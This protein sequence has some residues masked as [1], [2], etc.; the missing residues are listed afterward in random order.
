MKIRIALC[1][2]F[3]VFK[4][5]AQ[6]KILITENDEVS[7][8]ETY[9]SLNSEGNIFPAV[10]G[11]GLIYASNHKSSF[12]KLYFSDLKSKSTK[13]KIGSKY[14]LG[15]VATFEN[16][17]YFTGT[18]KNADSK[19]D[20]NFT[21][22]KGILSDFKVKDVVQLQVCNLDFS[23]TYPTISK[24]GKTMVVVSNE[25]GRLHLLE[26]KR[27]KNNEWIKGEVIFISQPEF[28]IL[29]PTI[30]DENTIYFAS[31]IYEGKVTGVAYDKDDKG[32]IKITQVYREQGDFNI[33]KMVKNNNYWS[34][35]VKVEFF[36][37]EFDDLGVI[38][39]DKK[40]G[41]LTSYRYSD[42][43]NIYYFELKQ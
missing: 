22:Y 21:I 34:L 16:E 39:I 30:Y 23:F 27:D 40:S 18:S 37:S 12:Y 35:P 4:I 26:F 20:Y 25:K 15:A 2:F 3:F 33:Y 19:G 31:N 28:E 38:F 11:E 8:F 10:Y 5:I 36:N 32:E 17:I 13:F 7:L 14:N 43:D 41:Y 29:N 9:L 24:D 42:S 6:E 1:L